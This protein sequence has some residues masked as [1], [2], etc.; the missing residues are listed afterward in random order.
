MGR[1]LKKTLSYALRI[2]PKN[3]PANFREILFTHNGEIGLETN[4]HKKRREET[5]SGY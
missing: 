5:A 2:D 3:V 4:V 1:K